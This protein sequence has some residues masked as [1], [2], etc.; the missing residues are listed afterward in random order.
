MNGQA[1]VQA[2]RFSLFAI[3]F[4]DRTQ[5]M[6]RAVLERFQEPGYAFVFAPMGSVEIL[7]V[8]GDMPNVLGSVSRIRAE[9]SCP[10]VILAT[11]ERD[12]IPDAECL[13]NPLSPRAFLDAL[14]RAADR[15]RLAQ[16]AVPAHGGDAV[17][18]QFDPGAGLQGIAT[19]ATRMESGLGELDYRGGYLR[20][21]DF[22]NPEHVQSLYF[23]AEGYLSHHLKSA[24]RGLGDGPGI[25]ELQINGNAL[26]V[27]LVHNRWGGA[28]D[29]QALQ[30]LCLAPLYANPEVR[31][32]AAP[33]RGMQI[34]GRVEKVYGQADFSQTQH[35]IASHRTRR[36]EFILAQIGLWC[37]RGHL[38][39]G[40]DLNAPLRLRYWPNLPHLPRTLGAMQIAAIWMQSPC[41]LIETVRRTGLQ[42]RHVF[43]FFVICDTLGLFEA[44]VDNAAAATAS[45]VQGTKKRRGEKIP[46]ASNRGFLQRLLAKV[47]RAGEAA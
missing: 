42:Q 8:N 40:T 36:A 23:N 41:S 44:S 35:L 6:L 7:I 46:G 26:V 3:G 16:I 33:P 43:A 39:A 45:R 28:F 20:D 1:S 32:L 5:G 24:I 10:V 30:G 29:E 22:S 47:W 12:D 15:L 19:A 9:R 37:A 4:S 18:V 38:P 25:I 13:T 14:K 27:D 31:R 17:P 21:I 2:Q 34:Q 11:R